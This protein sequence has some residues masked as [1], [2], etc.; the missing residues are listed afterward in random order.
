[1]SSAHMAGLGIMSEFIEVTAFGDL[2]RVVL[3]K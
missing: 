2:D 3:V 1:M